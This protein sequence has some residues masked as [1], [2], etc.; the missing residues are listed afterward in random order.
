MRGLLLRGQREGEG[1]EEPT[2]KGRK[3]G[4]EP[5]SKGDGREEQGDGTGREFSPK[6]R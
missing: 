2:Y 4:E 5:T 3:E 6:S 1:G